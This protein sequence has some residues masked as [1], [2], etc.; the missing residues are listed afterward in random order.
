MAGKTRKMMTEAAGTEGAPPLAWRCDHQ[1]SRLPAIGVT[2]RCEADVNSYEP[3]GGQPLF[4]WRPGLY[5]SWRLLDCLAHRNSLSSDSSIISRVR[6]GGV[7]RDLPRRD[8]LSGGIGSE[9]VATERTAVWRA[10]AA[11]PL[12]DFALECLELV[13]EFHRGLPASGGPRFLVP[14]T[15]FFGPA[16]QLARAYREGRAE[17]GE[18]ARAAAQARMPWLS[19]PVA[20]AA[21]KAANNAALLAS[22]K[23][24][25]EGETWA[26]DYAPLNARL[27]RRLFDMGAPR[28]DPGPPDTA[29]G[30]I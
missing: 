7:I 25:G 26:L 22:Y 18:F 14:P 16:L 12:F 8:V 15:P 4:F 21:F 6:L 27:E 28:T 20:P 24:M 19:G 11:R 29:A 9:V 13:Q 1:E 30:N 3:V 2:E 5:A 10:D 17:H 23:A